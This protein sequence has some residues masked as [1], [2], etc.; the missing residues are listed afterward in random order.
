MIQI[1]LLREATGRRRIWV[2]KKS[3]AELWVGLLV[4]AAVI[5]VLGWHWHLSSVREAAV[6]RRA[7]LQ[8]ESAQLAVVRAELE[9]YEAQRALLEERARIIENLRASQRGP[10]QMMNAIIGAMPNEPRLW[11][12][13]LSQQEGSVTIEGYAFD[14]PAIADFIANLGKYPP[15][16]TVELAFWE[17]R[18]D[19]VAFG[20]NCRLK[21]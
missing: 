18:Q 7:E 15:F 20:L 12:T 8:Q 10:V 14:V 2:P 21:N 13:T 17:D 9:R 1:N 4:A 5:G 11:L 19:S 6:I 16:Q 3:R